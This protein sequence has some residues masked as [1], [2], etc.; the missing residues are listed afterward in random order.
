MD[1]MRVSAPSERVQ[2]LDLLRAVAILVVALHHT[3]SNA[4]PAA[5]LPLQ[6]FGWMGVDLFFVL[7]GYLI[8]SQLLK[9]HALGK[10]PAIADFYVRRAFRILPAFLVVLCAYFLVPDFREQ[11]SIAPL[12]KFVTFTMNVGLDRSKEAAFSHAW[13][14]C[15]EEY[16]YILFP[17]ICVALMHRPSFKAAVIAC[18]FAVTAGIIIR[19]SSWVV[20]V[21]P[22]LTGSGTEE[23]L[24]VV[25][26]KY[27]YYPTYARLDGLLAGIV[28]SGVKIF[29]PAWWHWATERGHGTGLS[30]IALLT[31]AVWLFSDRASLSATVLGFPILSMG[32]GLLL[33]S[34]ISVNGWLARL[35]VPGVGTTATLAYSFYLTHK[36]VMH[37]DR[38]YLAGWLP[39]EGALALPVY[40]A[41]SFAGAALLY[42]CIEQPFLMLRS[43]IIPIMH[44]VAADRRNI[45]IR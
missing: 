39:I 36:A 31:L 4:V 29:R 10:K 35:Y 42:L 45:A 40:Y 43:Y 23:A 2:G 44:S 34:S 8:G 6:Q 14:L 26:P 15:V 32:L 16:F 41:T 38:L 22:V 1:R 12:W 25:Y 37:L 27:I 18:L 9:Q 21:A 13:S 5:L 30:G 7:S 20:Y 3:A 33:V 28:L 17:L 11:P 24:W 19:L